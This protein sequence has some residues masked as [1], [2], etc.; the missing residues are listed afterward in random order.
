MIGSIALNKDGTMVIVGQFGYVENG[1]F[2]GYKDKSF[3][4]NKQD[5][6]IILD[7]NPDTSLSRRQDFSLAVYNYL[8]NNNLIDQGQIL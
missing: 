3:I 7:V 8:L 6:D 1:L 4:L 5:S 2:V